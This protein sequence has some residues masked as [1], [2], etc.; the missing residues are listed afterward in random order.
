MST[1]ETINSNFTVY[2]IDIS[3]YQGNEI[4][5]LNKQTNELSFV[6]CKATE[7]ITYADPN[8]KSNWSAI[9]SKGYVRGAYH[10]YHCND[11]PVEQAANYLE[12]TGLISDTD[13]PPI[14]DFE[15]VSI[16][17]G[18]N[19]AD[20]QPNLLQFLTLLQQ[21]TGRKPILYTTNNTANKYLTNPEFANFYL[22]I[23][24]YSETLTL[25]TI[26]ESKGWTLWQKTS[27]Y[28]LYNQLN[29]YDVFN[30]DAN[31]FSEFILSSKT[32]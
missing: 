9:R 7:G 23:A 5:F 11:D 27:G 8:F 13:L 19:A 1:T 28:K 20:I 15:G 6:I 21:K 18:I 14:V 31:A 17:P 2:G 30:G 29:D 3:R 10:F 4:R 22:W 25:P 32:G 16:D 24:D 12:V 26:W